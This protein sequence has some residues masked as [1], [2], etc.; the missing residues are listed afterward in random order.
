MRL[1]IADMRSCISLRGREGSLRV[2]K[3][4]ETEWLSLSVKALS[5]A[6]PKPAIEHFRD[7]RNDWNT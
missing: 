4:V 5:S 6:I 3:R 2:L 7:W 1:E